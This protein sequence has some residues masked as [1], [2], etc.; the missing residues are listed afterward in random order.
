MQATMNSMM[1]LG[2]VISD[3]CLED[4]PIAVLPDAQ[5]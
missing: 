4:I 1:R 5:C 3:F 2:L